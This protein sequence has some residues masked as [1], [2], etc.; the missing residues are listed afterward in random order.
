MIKIW[1]PKIFRL[2]CMANLL[3]P[4]EK[5]RL[6]STKGF[7]TLFLGLKGNILVRW[8]IWVIWS[9]L[10]WKSWYFCRSVLSVFFN[11]HACVCVCTLSFLLLQCFIYFI[12]NYARPNARLLVLLVL[13]KLRM[14]SSMWKLSTKMEISMPWRF[15]KY[16]TRR[17]LTKHYLRW[18]KCFLAHFLP[19]PEDC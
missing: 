6:R 1:T 18:F 14:V 17:Q 5:Y 9:V 13:V 2:I 3:S 12:L 10:R 8:S 16:G 15:R 4:P 11:F 19:T 7:Y